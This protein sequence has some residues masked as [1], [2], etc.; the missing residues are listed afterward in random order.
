[1]RAPVLLFPEKNASALDVRVHAFPSV[2]AATPRCS[3]GANRMHCH[4]LLPTR[5]LAVSPPRTD[6][7]TYSA[8]NFA[9]GRHA[10]L[11]CRAA[12]HKGRCFSR[13]VSTELFF[14]EAIYSKRRIQGFFA[15]HQLIHTEIHEM[16][17]DGHGSF[18]R[19]KI[20]G[21]F[22]EEVLSLVL[23]HLP[24]GADISVS[25]SKSAEGAM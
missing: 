11:R 7:A 24:K 8:T 6:V 2:G 1:M 3:A 16:S 21:N 25:A 12:H 19:T 18:L 13:K 14:C 17:M 10:P 15:G 22:N 9:T 20:I 5:R 23:L 4:A